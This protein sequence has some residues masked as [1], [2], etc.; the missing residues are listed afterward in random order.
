MAEDD[1]QAAS[2]DELL[3]TLARLQ[4]ALAPRPG[5]HFWATKWV[6]KFLLQLARP[7]ARQQM[8]F[9]RVMLEAMEAQR[10][11]V[12][13][14]FAGLRRHLERQQALPA[15]GTI[16]GVA[17][18]S[19][20]DSSAAMTEALENGFFLRNVMPGT[21]NI[22]DRKDRW[23]VLMLLDACR[24]DV[25]ERLHTGER[26]V[27]GELTR[28]ISPGSMTFEWFKNTFSLEGGREARDCRDIVYVSGNPVVSA[29]TLRHWGVAFQFAHLEEAWRE[30]WN[31][32]LQSVPPEAVASAYLRLRDQHPGKRFILHF[33]QPHQPYIGKTRFAAQ[34]A[35]GRATPVGP[36][37][38]WVDQPTHRN[39]VEQGIADVAQL[40]KAYEDNLRLVLG[41]VAGLRAKIPG[42]VVITAD[43]G[44]M[45]GEYG[46]FDHPPGLYL[47]QLI[48][49]PWLEVQPAG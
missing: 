7:F 31:V 26:I 6:K 20:P 1:P 11:E 25:M 28:I 17:A 30:G 34:A 39:I 15:A 3:A 36:D 13:L 14:T 5:P 21:T 42:R 2:A 46:K 37:G 27:P 10:R 19:E 49:V 23:D 45:L 40:R 47:P 33:L 22:L 8:D 44:E 43:H 12:R 24:F 32:E 41:V 16:A 9:N 48:E 38:L 4:P 18:G 29:A 35:A